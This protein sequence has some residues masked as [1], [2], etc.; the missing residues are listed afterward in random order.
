MLEAKRQSKRKLRFVEPGP[1]VLERLRKLQRREA[2]LAVAAA[3]E[4]TSGCAGDVVRE[5]ATAV[6][7]GT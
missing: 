2:G 7:V 3:T 6:D 4:G 1:L 5:G